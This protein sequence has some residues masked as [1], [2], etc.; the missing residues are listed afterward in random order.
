MGNGK[1][2]EQAVG[3][4]HVLHSVHTCANNSI[5]KRKRERE[6]VD[7]EPWRSADI[8]VTDIRL[9]TS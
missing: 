4:G 1:N 3:D 8:H 6:T 9:S 7:H 5:R 2:R